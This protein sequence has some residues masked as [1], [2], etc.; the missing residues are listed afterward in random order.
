MTSRTYSSWKC[1]QAL[2]G[3]IDN[4]S[5]PLK[6]R[7]QLLWPQL[8]AATGQQRQLET[9]VCLRCDAGDGGC[10]LQHSQSTDG[11]GRRVEG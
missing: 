10:S 1:M 11:Q 5:R 4:I 3:R 9:Q 7:V 6:A 2:A 8:A